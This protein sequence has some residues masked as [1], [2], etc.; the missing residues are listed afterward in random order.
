MNLNISLLSPFSNTSLPV[1]LKFHN[2][3]KTLL[4]SVAM[5]YGNPTKIHRQYTPTPNAVFKHPTKMNRMNL[6]LMRKNGFNIYLSGF[7]SYA[8]YQ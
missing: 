7:N 1:V 3:P 6:L 5:K 8:I 4:T 2:T